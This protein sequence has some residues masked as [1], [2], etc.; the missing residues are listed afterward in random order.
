M[1]TSAIERP[2]APAFPRIAP[3][4]SPGDVDREFQPGQ[5][6]LASGLDHLAEVAPGAG[7]DAGPVHAQMLDPVHDDEPAESRVADE[8]VRAPSRSGAHP[9]PRADRAPDHFLE[10]LFGVDLGEH[11]GRSADPERGVGRD[12]GAALDDELFLVE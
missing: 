5:G 2:N 10:R 7:R 8:E 9:H 4:D 11:V 1:T 3:P 12:G 6:A